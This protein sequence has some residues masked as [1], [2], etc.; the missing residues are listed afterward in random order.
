MRKNNENVF[1][2]TRNSPRFEKV[3]Q[4]LKLTS[5]DDATIY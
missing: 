3:L 4:I 1:F 2:S 5:F